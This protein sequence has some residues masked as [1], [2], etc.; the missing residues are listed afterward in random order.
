MS[1][2]MGGYVAGRLAGRAPGASEHEVDV[3]D[4]LHGVIVWGV[5]V[6][7]AALIAFVGVGGIGATSQATD[8][9]VGS[10]IARVIDEQVNEAAA[11][12]V[13][14]ASPQDATAAERRAEVARKLSVI[15]GFV[16]A[17]SLRVGAVAAFFGAHSG[18]NHRDK[19]VRWDFFASKARVN[20]KVEGQ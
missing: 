11:E 20:R 5:G 3:R 14:A 13:P 4:G 10:S 15:S 17:A 1:F 8:T 16:T 6:I 9:Q 7:A 18:G 19:D 2:F 12:E